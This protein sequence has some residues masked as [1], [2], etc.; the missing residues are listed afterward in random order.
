MVRQ[1]SFG[2]AAES[3]KPPWLFLRGR[4]SHVVSTPWGRNRVAGE[5]QN[6]TIRLQL[7]CPARHAPQ[8]RTTHTMDFRPTPH[9]PPKSVQLLLLA[10][11]CAI[12]AQAAG[13]ASRTSVTVDEGL[14]IT[15]GYT[16]LRTG[17][18]RLVEE[19][20]PLLKILMALP[21]LPVRDLPDSTSLPGW[22]SD[23]AVTDSVRLVRATQSLIYPYRPIDRLV[24]AARFPVVLLA[25]LLG[26]VTFR[27]AADLWGWQGGLLATV[28]LAFDPNVLAHASVAGTDLGAACFI[29]LSVF[30]LS[31]FLDKPG[32]P[33][34]ALAGVTLGLAQAAKLSSLAL[35]PIEALLVLLVL[36]KRRII[37]LLAMFLIAATVLWGVYGFEI[38]NVPGVP[39]PVPAASHSI[40]WLR[41]RQHV[42]DGHAAFLLGKNSSHGWW[43]YFPVAFL[44]KTPLPTLLLSL[45]S[46]VVFLTGERSSPAK[47]ACLLCFPLLYWASSMLSPLNI[48]YRHLLPVLPFLVIFAARLPVVLAREL[49]RRSGAAFA[50]LRVS[51]VALVVWLVAGTA[52]LSPHY[53]A[54]FNEASGGPD[55]GWRSLAD[56]NTDWGQAYKDLARFQEDQRLGEV[57]LSAFIF[58]DPAI[59]GIEY[60][61]LTPLRGNTPAIFPSRFNPPPGDYVISSTT[62]D[63]IPLADPEMFD[64]FRKHEPDSKIGHVLFYYHV[65]PRAEAANWLA[66]CSVPTSP[67]SEAVAREGFSRAGLRLAHF[68]CTQAWLLPA[69]G[70]SSGWYAL[71]RNDVIR[72]EF[73]QENLVPARM[74]YEQTLP[75][76]TPPFTIYEWP[77][78][79]IERVP[80][81]AST[82]PFVAAPSGAALADTDALQS[83]RAPVLL[84]DTLSFL[85]YELEHDRLLPS[86]SF[87]LTTYWEVLD[88][89]LGPLSLMAHLVDELEQPLS[90]GDG[91]GVPVESWHPGDVII[92]RHMLQVPGKAPPGTY[93]LQTGVYRLSDLARLPIVSPHG[94]GADRIILQPVEVGP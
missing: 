12:C 85:G 63:G 23:I 69:G 11:L 4:R 91:L 28:L 33:R 67:L 18:F 19:H 10:L 14:H 7:M 68:D 75:R 51:L 53:L 79:D 25:V 31:R 71:Y 64:W 48:G 83:I 9:Q 61:P 20:P 43:Y 39:F 86:D 21:L 45:A 26:A 50:S 81:G 70:S 78:M 60:E 57:R 94:S 55:E 30:C 59:Y 44:L 35:L 58:Y 24:F 76:E 27:W 46:A 87:H 88:T 92:Q 42:A 47:E 34:L 22:K 38:G 62:L 66:Q 52:R 72:Q 65:P 74:A 8:E 16:I 37:S 80:A 5:V 77:A 6:G 84:S 36:R 32:L 15:S 93:W 73:T 54:F 49:S 90:N 41:L 29:T 89:P 1:D 3:K 17:D 13:A 40:P 2:G 82:G 56:S